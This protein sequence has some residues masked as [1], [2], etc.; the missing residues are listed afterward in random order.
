MQYIELV[1]NLMPQ[2]KVKIENQPTN[3]ILI[4]LR[5]LILRDNFKYFKRYN[6]D[7][8]VMFKEALIIWRCILKYLCI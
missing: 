8:V 1:W 5:Y 7:I 2:T 3:S 6:N 4:L